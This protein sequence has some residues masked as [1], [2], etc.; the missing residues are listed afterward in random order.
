MSDPRIARAA[1]L[2]AGWETAQASRPLWRKALD[3]ARSHMGYA[4]YRVTAYGRHGA[5]TMTVTE[6]PADRERAYGAR[7]TIERIKGGA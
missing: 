7:H 2:Y 5:V 3:V 1:R 6:L 4:L